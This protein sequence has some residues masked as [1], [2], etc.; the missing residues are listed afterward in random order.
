MIVVPEG[1]VPKALIPTTCPPPEAQPPGEAPPRAIAKLIA[2]ALAM[3]LVFWASQRPLLPGPEDPVRWLEGDGAHRFQVLI[4]TLLADPQRQSDGSCQALLAMAGG[5]TELRLRSCPDLREGWRLRVSGELARLP[6][7]PHPLLAGP[8]ER[9]AR[10][11]CWTRL[12]VESLVV[13][14]RP[15]TPVADLRR[16]I[17]ERF[18]ASAGPERGGLLAALVL[19]SAVVPLPQALREAFRVSG[20]SHALAASGFHLTVLLGAVMVVA[21]PCGK[22]GRL[23]LAGGAILLFLLLAG[24]QPSVVRAVLMG[25]LALAAREVGLR[26]RPLGLLGLSVAAMLL[27]R[28]DWLG[29]VGFQLSVAATAGLVVSADPMEQGLRPP[30][31]ALPLVPSAWREP[32]AAALA[33]ALAVPLAAS[34]W[35]L[36]LQLLH[37]GVVPLWAVPANVLAAPLLTPLTLGAMAAAVVGL[38]APPLQALAMPPL[39]WLAQALLAVAHGA[40]ALPM[41]Q[42]HSG[43]LPLWLVTVFSLGLLGWVSPRAGG[44]RARRAWASA[45]LLLAT[46]AH[47]QA[48]RTDALVLVQDGPRTLLLARHDG[49]GALISSRADPISCRHGQRLASGYGLP[50]YDWLLL[51]DGVSAPDPGCWQ[52]LAGVVVAET[53]GLPPLAA[54]RSLASAGL[55]ARGIAEESQALDLTIGHARWLLLPNPQALWSW[56][57]QHLPAKASVWLGFSPGP[58]D[59]R[60]LVERG[61]Q[62]VWLSG[63]PPPNAPPMAS[64]WLHTGTR[65]HLSGRA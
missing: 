14:A 41:A 18:L 4:G 25:T 47:L 28:P 23:L 21:R 24:P 5:R 1:G 55:V 38:V 44:R 61:A 64:G 42:W 35:T 15:G 46:L 27:V 43:R 34:L 31:T 12:Q 45:L 40:A 50:R 13:L 10:Q 20:L 32:L 51:L 57:R 53:D 56:R 48:L 63:A 36:P 60:L 37:F 65:G 54:G 19:G 59:R 17:A 8:A 16:R 6:A 33:P 26:G 52:R 30:L 62:R 22:G 58:R 39:G 3:A 9:L 2:L 29:D 7:A 49:R 11:G